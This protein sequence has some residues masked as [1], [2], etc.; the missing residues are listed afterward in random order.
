[1]STQQ[2]REFF[3]MATSAN[4][5][6]GFNGGRFLIITKAHRYDYGFLSH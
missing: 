6:R 1:M 5:V 4:V 2:R 3:Q